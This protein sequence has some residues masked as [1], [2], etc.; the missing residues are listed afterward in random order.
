ME[1]ELG[2]LTNLKDTIQDANLNF[3]VG[4][5]LSNPFLGLLGNIEE[6]LSELDKRDDIEENKRKIIRAAFYK[7]YCDEVILKN[8]DILNDNPAVVSTL[9]NY[10]NF[11]K[12]INSILRNRYSPI[13]NKQVNLF[14]T[15]IDIF[16]EKAFEGLGVECNDGFSGRFSPVFNLSNF[17]KSTLR[18]SF[19]YDNTS[20]IPI[21]NLFK[22][23]GSLTWEIFGEHNEKK[24]K[25][26]P[27]LTE[28]K[29]LKEKNFTEITAANEASTIATLL[30]TTENKR[31]SRSI[32]N[33][34]ELY[35]RLPIINPTKDKFKLTLLNQYH[36]E[37][38]R[39]YANE[40][41]KE[42]SVLFVMGFSFADEHIRE[43]T[44]RAINSN[45]TLTV[46]IFAH[47]SDSKSIYESRLDLKNIKNRNI[48][49]IVPE[50]NQTR[51]GGDTFLYDFENINLKIFN[52]LLK[53]IEEKP[54]E[55]K[56]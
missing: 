44:L 26:S 30:G 21:F 40:L 47:S 22:L 41:E 27:N 28:V 39:I 13:L 14:T 19:H 49:I 25:F 7:Q 6:S 2:D 10:K 43:I 3:L 36:Y 1:N 46:Y 23:H 50:Q 38:L 34:L 35:Q 51:Q 29:N 20:E 45:P 5:G 17:R 52:N 55:K 18:K 4:S 48:K 33:F 16:F 9:N 8:L 53:K 54:K 31:L 24:I 15:N 32:E 11:L 37:L 12:I 42:N 56:L